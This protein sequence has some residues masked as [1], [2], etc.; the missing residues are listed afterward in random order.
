[1]END[2]KE[3]FISEEDV[4]EVL[5]KLCKEALLELEKDQR[6]WWKST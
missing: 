5:S 6:T 1:M 3:G 2:P 4:K